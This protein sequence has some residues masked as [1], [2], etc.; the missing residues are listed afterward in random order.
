[1]TTL[2]VFS[3]LVAARTS[4]EAMAMRMAD[5]LEAEDRG[6]A[7]NQRDAADQAMSSEAAPRS[8]VA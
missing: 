6:L 4:W 5:L 1:M 8:A 7:S 3:H 2:I